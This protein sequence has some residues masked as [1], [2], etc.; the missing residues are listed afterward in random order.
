MVK[1]AVSGKGGVGK[2]TLTAMLAYLFA[3][4]GYNVTAIDCDSSINL[5][6]VL[7]VEEEIKPISEL[8]DVIEE[9]VRGPLGTYKL[10]PK[11][12]D[13]FEAHSKKNEH[14]IRVLA[15]GTIE[16]GGEGCFCPQNAFLRAILRHAIFKR[17]D[18]LL[19]DM[20]AGIE[21]LGRGTARGVDLLI[22]VVEPGMRSFETLK[23]IQKLAEDIG[24]KKIGVV[25]NKYIDNES[26][27]KLIDMISERYAL[28]G[29]IP[30]NECFIK[31]DLENIPPYEL[32]CEFESFKKIKEEVLKLI[33]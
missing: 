14:G 4:D 1:I 32:E 3:K 19:L 23:R 18:V 24:I 22:A 31:A 11:V 20:E 17:K 7:G 16:K 13:V 8:E 26:S 27:R 15:L 28:L 5:P 33:E 2:T 6:T 12:D 30:Y 29:R 9:R 10:N 25:L 21:H